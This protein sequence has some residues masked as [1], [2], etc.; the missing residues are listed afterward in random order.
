M[1]IQGYGSVSQLY[2]MNYPVAAKKVQGGAK[3]G[4]VPHAARPL[5]NSAKCSRGQMAKTS[6]VLMHLP[7]TSM[8]A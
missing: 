7:N 2:A 4:V 1:N 8:G 3:E 6:G 5:V